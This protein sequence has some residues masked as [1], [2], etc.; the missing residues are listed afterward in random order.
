[1]LEWCTIVQPLYSKG[2]FI[3]DKDYAAYDTLATV[4][5]LQKSVDKNDMMTE[6]E[7]LE[8]RGQLNPDVDAITP[9]RR[10]MKRRKKMH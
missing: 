5:K 3:R 8:M 6:K 7:I 10:F 4:E 1:M 2:F 9:T